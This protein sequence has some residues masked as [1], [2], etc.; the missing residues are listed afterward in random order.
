[1]HEIEQKAKDL[2]IKGER[3]RTAT[4]K[5]ENAKE[6]LFDKKNHSKKIGGGYTPGIVVIW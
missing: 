4:N 6:D 1:M 2:R 5:L 3:I